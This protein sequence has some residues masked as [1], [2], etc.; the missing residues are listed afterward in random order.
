MISAHVADQLM[1]GGPLI[2]AFGA[3]RK[4]LN[5]PAMDGY[6]SESDRYKYG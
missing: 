2:L 1:H 5:G 4:W 6:A 3:L